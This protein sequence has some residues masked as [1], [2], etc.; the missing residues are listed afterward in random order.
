MIYVTSHKPGLNT[1]LETRASSNNSYS[2]AASD[3]GMR[4]LVK[5]LPAVSD[6]FNDE[7]RQLSHAGLTPK[8]FAS[9][10][11]L[12]TLCRGPSNGVL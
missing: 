6:R 9:F 3:S 10:P 2:A 1:T 5:N 11:V 8:T 4:V 12:L 7:A